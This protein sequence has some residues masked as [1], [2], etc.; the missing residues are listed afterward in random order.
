[1]ARM[2]PAESPASDDVTAQLTC[3]HVGL[4]ASELQHDHGVVAFTAAE[5]ESAGK[6]AA[7]TISVHDAV[8]LPLPL[9]DRV[10]IHLPGF[11]GKSLLPV[12]SWLATTRLAKPGAE[13]IWQVS[14]QQGPDSVRRLL[15]ELGW[16]LKRDRQGRV[17]FLRG[18]CPPSATLPPPQSFAAVLGKK[19]IELLADYGIFSPKR[20]DDGTSLLLDIAL[21]Q[22]PIETVADIGIGYGAVAIGIVLNRVA[23]GTVGTDVDG[24]ALWL[25]EQNARAH[26]V[27][28]RLACTPD[29]AAVEFTSLTVCNV[30]THIDRQQSVRFMAG[31]AERARHGRLLAV[32]HTSLEARYAQ[33]LTAAGLHVHRHPGTAHVVLDANVRQR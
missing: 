9:S 22:P 2:V 17:I 32:V 4:P 1:M 3:W 30:P 14:K 18:V 21:Q 26:S 29:P 24:L 13:V 27:P 16:T 6:I 25:A 7:S 28:I 23:T 31:L 5:I 8:K 12:L 15:G 11:R 19:R 33:H 10:E 20:I